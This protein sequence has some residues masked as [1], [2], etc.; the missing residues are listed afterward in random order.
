MCV[1]P[2]ETDSYEMW[3]FLQLQSVAA[4]AIQV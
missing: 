1:R 2:G 4:M 3:Y